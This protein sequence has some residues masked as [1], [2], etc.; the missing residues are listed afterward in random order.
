MTTAQV[1]ARHLDAMPEAVQREVLD[2]VEFL[3]TRTRPR[4]VRE[5]DASWSGF[6]IT[7]AMR[8]MEDEPSPYTVDDLK[9][10]FH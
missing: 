9:E 2:F 3:E 5:S 8:G 10:S 6:S 7:A 4:M 1:I